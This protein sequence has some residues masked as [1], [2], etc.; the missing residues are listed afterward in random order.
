ML[1][2]I[3][4]VGASLAGLRAAETLRDRGFDGE[5]TLIGEE[6]PSSPETQLRR[7]ET[8]CPGRRPSQLHCRVQLQ[9]VK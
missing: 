7:K 3:V 8:H 1:H 6:P 2:R 5:L 9:H 4:V